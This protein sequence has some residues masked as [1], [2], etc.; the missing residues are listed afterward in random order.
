MKTPKLPKIKWVPFYFVR[1]LLSLY[2]KFVEGVVNIDY[3]EATTLLT[4]Y[5]SFQ[6]KKSRLIIAFRHPTKHDPALLMYILNKRLK[7]A[8]REKDIVIGGKT[9]AYILYG[10]WVLN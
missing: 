2:V 3:T 7:K 6:Q 4:M 9:H 8:G 1:T 5:S 10:S